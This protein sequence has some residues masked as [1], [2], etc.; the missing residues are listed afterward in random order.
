MKFTAKTNWL[1]QPLRGY[2]SCSQ[3]EGQWLCLCEWVNPSIR[4]LWG[5][6]L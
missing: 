3:A 6:W 5:L 4:L 1:F 2:P